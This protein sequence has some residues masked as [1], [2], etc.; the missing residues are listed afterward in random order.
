MTSGPRSLLHA[1]AVAG[2]L[3]LVVP[4]AVFAEEEA[5][6]GEQER[7]LV[8]R[9]PGQPFNPSF[10]HYAGYVT[11]SEQRGAALFYWFFEAAEDP[12]SKPLVLWLNGGPGCSSIAF[13]PGEEVGPFHVNADGK[14]VHLNPYS[15][16]KVANI[17][18]LDSPVGVGY[19]YSNTS[20]DVL[21]N[22]DA[23]TAKDSLAF[24]L[25]WLE[26]FPQYKG[27]EFYL[28]GES[29]LVTTFLNWLKP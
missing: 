3:L 13:G 18:F 16:N 22:G 15:W 4:A 25:K 1:V 20:D 14:G 19:S 6:R 2:L 23:R 17:L 5:W 10:A 7:D 8:P 29:M 12:A 11:V 26:R 28:T 21:T 24:L 27:R 9:V